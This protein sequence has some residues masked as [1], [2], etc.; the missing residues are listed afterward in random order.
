MGAEKKRVLYDA[1]QESVEEKNGAAKIMFSTHPKRSVA[2]KQNER[3]LRKK[4]EKK[5]PRLSTF[6]AIMI[7]FILGVLCVGQYGIIQDMGLKINEKQTALDDINAN[8]EA[9]RNE[10]AALG[11]RN[12][13]KEK[14][15]KDLGMQEAENVIVYTPSASNTNAQ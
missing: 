9:L 12:T 5:K 11:N 10:S 3:V 1:H 14:A 13:V 6:R 15:E 4:F 7:A 8:N 2:K